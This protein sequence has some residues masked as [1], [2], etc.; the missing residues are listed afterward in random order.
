ML[1]ALSG[2]SAG[3][4]LAKEAIS[5][6][7]G[8]GSKTENAPELMAKA[9]R[10]GGDGNSENVEFLE[11][12]AS[13]SRDLDAIFQSKYENM[14]SQEDRLDF[15]KDLFQAEKDGA[16]E[17]GTVAGMLARSA[18]SSG[19]TNQTMA[20]D[21][22]K[23]FEEGGVEMDQL[24]AAKPGSQL[25]NDAVRGE[26]GI[27]VRND[28]ADMI[29]EIGDPKLR[30]DFTKSLM[31]QLKNES[32]NLDAYRAK[33]T[34]KDGVDAAVKLANQGLQAGDKTPAQDVTRSLWESPPMRKE[35]VENAS[36]PDQ[37]TN[38]INQDYGRGDSADVT[39]SLFQELVKNNPENED[40]QKG[41]H[42]YFK[43]N[44]PRLTSEATDP[45]FGIGKQYADGQAVPITTPD[46]S[47]ANEMDDQDL[48]KDYTSKSLLN[49]SVTDE[50]LKDRFKT[51]S[52][53]VDSLVSVVNDRTENMETREQ[54][55]RELRTLVTGVSSGIA[56]ATERA[57]EGL[58]NKNDVA[59]KSLKVIGIL[60]DF[61]GGPA[62]PF[63]STGADVIS[64]WSETGEADDRLDKSFI[65]AAVAK[66][67][68]PHGDNYQ[69]DSR[70]RDLVRRP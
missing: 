48:I 20:D 30:Q 45:G 34:F 21:L 46:I 42:N 18:G 69:E 6:F 57:Q 36:K 50:Q 55:A 4:G 40:A 3:I 33:D 16:A 22:A 38:L 61:F 56:D 26:N 32:S 47:L 43:D 66:L 59:N 41:I 52:N 37:L 44:L 29:G 7:D 39:E 62:G 67:N 65:D 8:G 14:D 13:H 19:I 64:E 10:K 1:G 51:I 63:I 17:K 25:A 35:F 68:E 54:A 60:G 23:L 24:A 58:D 11:K 12:F 27:S 28:L 15:L 31:E 5:L 2:I 70:L 9:D 49:D 53:Q